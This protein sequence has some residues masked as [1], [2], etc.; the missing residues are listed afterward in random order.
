MSLFDL[1][2]LILTAAAF[3]GAICYVRA[4]DSLTSERRHPPETVP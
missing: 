4:C 3:A 1:A 2:M